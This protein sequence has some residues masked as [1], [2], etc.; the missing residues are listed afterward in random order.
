MYS[1]VTQLHQLGTGGGTKNVALSNN[2]AA[3]TATDAAATDSRSI[4]S[5]SDYYEVERVLATVK[6]VCTVHISLF[7]VI[8]MSLFIMQRNQQRQFLVKW[9]GFPSDQASWVSEDD[10]TEEVLRFADIFFKCQFH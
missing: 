5:T 8:Y 7:N 10:C 9:K 6:K 1:F 4:T 3:P 2:T